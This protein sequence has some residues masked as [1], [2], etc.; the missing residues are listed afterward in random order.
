MLI[1]KLVPPQI[2]LCASMIFAVNA[3]E[4]GG[5]NEA[6]YVHPYFLSM[7]E[8][9]SVFRDRHGTEKFEAVYKDLMQLCK[10]SSHTWAKSVELEL[11]R[12]HYFSYE[13]QGTI[14][15]KISSTQAFFRN[16]AG[17]LWVLELTEALRDRNNS[18][19]YNWEEVSAQFHNAIIKHN[20]FIKSTEL[21]ESFERSID[22]KF[23]HSDSKAKRFI[24]SMFLKLEH[25]PVFHKSRE[26]FTVGAAAL[27]RH[28]IAPNEWLAKY[29][30]VVLA[31]DMLVA[32]KNKILVSAELSPQSSTNTKQSSLSKVY[33]KWLGNMI[34]LYKNEAE[35]LIKETKNWIGE[36]TFINQLGLKSDQ[37][38]MKKQALY[39]WLRN[40]EQGVFISA[41][42]RMASES[43]ILE[44][45]Y[46]LPEGQV[47]DGLSEDKVRLVANMLRHAKR[48]T[49]S[50][51]ILRLNLDRILKESFIDPDHLKLLEILISPAMLTK[52]P[53]LIEETLGV[54]TTKQNRFT[55]EDYTRM[56]EQTLSSSSGTE[57]LHSIH[58]WI[59]YWKTYRMRARILSGAK[60]QHQA[61][62]FQHLD[63]PGLQV[64]KI[65]LDRPK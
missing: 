48:D 49:E 21:V 32:A 29:L 2:L 25:S 7:E 35:T 51:F 28:H 31:P 11:A 39:A 33:H 9:M 56:L 62:L 58:Y 60:L 20:N 47:G 18:Q 44:H 36:K 65:G 55:I 12:A 37:S 46:L 57:P 40:L 10:E 59:H 1:L 16:L 50:E 8:S 15:G 26:D 5:L 19:V 13:T 54:Y 3:V 53:D 52:Y 43:T 23:V 63:D 61:L 42:D 34:K 4:A 27:I 6:L 38:I 22:N 30:H 45:Q 14:L 64:C 41:V 17:D 24:K